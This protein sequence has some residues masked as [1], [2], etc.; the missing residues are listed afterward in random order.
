MLKILEA[1]YYKG[2][3]IQPL[4]IGGY[5]VYRREDTLNNEGAFFKT[6]EESQG[7]IDRVFLG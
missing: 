4:S 6:L 7:Y 1:L 5:S 2:W 3:V